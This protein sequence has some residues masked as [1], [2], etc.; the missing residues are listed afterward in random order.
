LAKLSS[1]NAKPKVG[2]RGPVYGESVFLLDEN[3]VEIF[4]DLLPV[5]A[6]WGVGPKTH[7]K[8]NALGIET[9]GELSRVSEGS[10][11]SSLGK[12][13]GQQLWRLARGIDN[14]N[15]VVEQEVKSIGHEETFSE[16]LTNREDVER[17]LVR[18]VDS[19]LWRLRKSE[20]KC[21]TVSLKIRYSDFTTFSRSC[22]FPGPTSLSST[23]LKEA[24]KLLGEVDLR[25]G[26][27]LLGISVTNFD[28]SF[29]E[30]L[31]FSENS[32]SN[33]KNT[34]D[35]VDLIR[36]RFGAA[37]IGPA[38]ILSSNGIRVK[39]KGEQQ[40]GPHENPSD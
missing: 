17:E 25:P 31:K 37:S 19:V 32:H 29:G 26:V 20:K 2:P 1:E 30:Q 15:I 36:D 33:R 7:K 18:L 3:E 4:L 28:K 10:L 11:V 22:T 39:R 12:A 6:I 21:R 8:L 34:E 14:R 24:K 16:D 35:A 27:R 38:S 23:V 9:V 40:W 5:N 13:A